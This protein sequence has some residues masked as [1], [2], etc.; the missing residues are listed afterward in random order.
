MCPVSGS[1]QPTSYYRGIEIN[2]GPDSFKGTCASCGITYYSATN[3]AN[4]QSV[5]FSNDKSFK[6]TCPLCDKTF[7]SASGYLS[8]HYR[9]HHN[10]PEQARGPMSGQ[11]AP[12][13]DV[14]SDVLLDADY[15]CSQPT[16]QKACR[17][18]KDLR[19]HIES[20][21]KSGFAM[22]CPFPAICPNNVFT[23]VSTFRTHCSQYHPNIITNSR[24]KITYQI[25]E[26]GSIAF[27][28]DILENEASVS[29]ESESDYESDDSD[30]SDEFFDCVKESRSP[31]PHD[32]IYP[33]NQVRHH[34]GKFYLWLEGVLLIPATK[35]QL[36]SEEIALLCE[37]SHHRIKVNLK[38]QLRREGIEANRSEKLIDTA[39]KADTIWAVHHKDKDVVNVCTDYMRKK[40]YRDRCAFLDSQEIPLGCN[41]SGKNKFA[42]FI[43]VKST[44]QVMFNDPTVQ[45]HIEKS[46]ER[47]STP[48]VFED[49]TDGSAFNEHP[50]CGLMNK[51]IQLTF[52]QDAFEFYP[53][54]PTAGTY[55]CVGFYFFLGNIHPNARSKVDAIQ[56][57]LIVKENDLK[58]FG[59]EAVLKVLIDELTDLTENGIKYKGETI[60]VVLNNMCGD[61]LGQHFIGGF[62]ESFTCEYFCRFCEVTKQ[63]LK[64]NPTSCLPFR[65][66][67]EY[68]KIAAELLSEENELYQKKG[69][70]RPSLL[71]K[72]P[73][74]H[75]CKGQPPCISHDILEGFAKKDFALFLRYFIQIK[76]WISFD[77]RNRRIHNFKCKGRDAADSLVTLDKSL[78]KIRGHASEV[79]LFIRMFPFLISDKIQD[80]E[81]PVWQLAILLKKICEYVFAPKISEEMAATLKQMTHLYLEQRSKIF[82]KDLLPKHHY[83]CHYA[84][85]IAIHGPLIRLWTMR[86]ESRHIF[87]KQAAKAANNF[88]NI[89]KTL[90]NK[91]ALNFAFKFTGHMIP[92]PITFKDNDI[93]QL[94]EDLNP[95]VVQI[96]R[97]DLSFDCVLKCVEVHGIMYE[98][99][100]WLLLQRVEQNR[101]LLYGEILLILYNGS[102]VKFIIKKTPG[103]RFS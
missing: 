100:M 8:H 13:A 28:D 43:P 84:D 80:Q 10:D 27:S 96:L 49:Y 99:E 16:C 69:I 33:E 15:R 77:V 4:H 6:F 55:K 20:H 56:L 14:L 94:P 48:G 5:H 67:E 78:T 89:T 44:L 59:I 32:N 7:H 38:E 45:Q 97:E 102:Q 18:L 50:I 52:F 2:P 22:N 93:S 79:W 65:T 19:S 34:V 25:K 81:D 71:N 60:P 1:Y 53:L 31:P 46:F 41:D 61:N 42:H 85:L 36:I 73:F 75:V 70:K 54:S 83:L 72:I 88:K 82:H 24:E 35:I 86:F 26:D 9:N 101:N 95:R 37:M 90:V 66:P 62:L 11:V 29:S 40:F 76:D 68:D 74:Y 51:T 63:M 30:K 3:Y 39:L 23:K 91:Y 87:F 58:Y 103:R 92:P 47:T 21:I 17:T 57:A 64:D 12:A 98:P